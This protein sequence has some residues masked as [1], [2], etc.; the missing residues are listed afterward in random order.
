VD[1]LLTLALLFT[2]AADPPPVVDPPPVAVSEVKKE[3]KRDYAA[4]YAAVLAG[5][6][7]VLVVGDAPSPGG[8]VYAATEKESGLAAGVYDLR[9]LAD[10][11]TPWWTR[12]ADAPRRPLLN[13]LNP[14]QYLPGRS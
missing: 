1:H 12:R 2:P 11:K 9:L 4:A 6:E 10:G 7:A 3:E 14:F 5:G 13:L 8:A